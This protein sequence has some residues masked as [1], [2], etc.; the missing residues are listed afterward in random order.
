M[1]NEI[2]PYQTKLPDSPI[3][4]QTG[5]TTKTLPTNKVASSIST[6]LFRGRKRAEAQKK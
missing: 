4:G 6:T 3:V 1:S 2:I 5:P